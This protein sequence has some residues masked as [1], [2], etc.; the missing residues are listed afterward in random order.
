MSCQ[1]DYNIATKYKAVR[2]HLDSLGYDLGFSL[3]CLPLIEKLLADLIQTTESLKHFK[4]IAQENIE[5]CCKLQSTIDPYKCDNIRLVRECNDLHEHLIA[6]K[7]THD[8]QVRDLKKQIKKLENE[9]SGFQ[10]ASSRNLKKIKELEIETSKKSK[11]ILELQGK[12]SKPHLTNPGLAN[13]KRNCHPLRRPALECE[14]LPKPSNS[15]PSLPS[16]KA[17]E[18]K[19]FDLLNMADHKMNCLSYEAATKEKEIQRLRKLLE[20]GRPH[21]A[22]VSDCYCKNME[23]HFNESQDNR[24]V[25]EL[26]ILQQTKLELEKELKDALQKQHEAMSHAM[27]LAE[28]NEELEKELRDIDNIAL[29][30]EA[31]CNTAVKVNHMRVCK[32]QQK[33]DD[34]VTQVHV[35]E[36]ELMVERREVQELRADLTACKLEKRNIQ[37]LFESALD[38]KKQM[39]DKINQLMINAS[40]NRRHSHSPPVL[41]RSN[42]HGR[43][44]MN[45]EN[46]VTKDTNNI[47][48]N[49]M[50]K[51]INEKDAQV[52]SLQKTI[53]KL[54][55]ERDFYKDEYN[56]LKDQYNKINGSDNM[57]ALARTNELHR[58]LAEKDHVLAELQ[59]EKHELCREKYNLESRLQ[60]YCKDY[61]RNSCSPCRQSHTCN[62]QVL[63]SCLQDNNSA[64]LLIDRLERERDTAKADVDRLVQERDA[65]RE[66][67]QVASETHKCEQKCLRENLVDVQNRLKNIE[68]ERHDVSL[69]QVTQRATISGLEDQLDDLRRELRRTKEE[70]ASQRTQ[71][72]QLKALQDQTDQALGDVQCQLTQSE[73]ELTKAVDRNRCMEQQQMQMDQQVKGLKQEINTLRS[74]MAQLDHEKDQLLMLLDEKTEKIEALE[75]DIMVKEQQTVGTEQQIRELQHKNEICVDQSAEQERQIRNLQMEIENVQRQLETSSSDRENAIQEN[76]RLQDDLASVSCEVRTLHREL[77]TSRA[78][79]SDLKRQLQTYVSEVRRAEELLNRKENERTEMLNHF[80]SLSLEASVLENNNHSLESEAAEARGALESARDKLLDLERQLADKESLTREYETQITQLTQSVASLEAQLRQQTEQREMAEAD[81]I[82]VRDLCMKLD[83]QK[84]SLMLQL[85]DKD[86]MKSQYEN[87][88]ARLKTEQNV[89]QDQLSRDR[90]A[91]DRLESLLDEARQESIKAQATNQQLQNEILRLKHKISDLQGK[92]CSESAE[93]RQYQNQAAEYNKQIIELRRQVTNER[94][95]RAMKDEESRRSSQDRTRKKGKDFE[96]YYSDGENDLIQ[97]RQAERPSLMQTCQERPSASQDTM[98]V[99]KMSPVN[100]TSETSTRSLNSTPDSFN[101]DLN[102]VI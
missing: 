47:L 38:E 30:V 39:T 43:K 87:Q 9:C 46:E 69:A 18:P 63:S 45:R 44:S 52:A 29:A 1:E 11:K 5:T 13:K 58:Q 3:D 48:Q 42:D 80:R 50:Q 28:R 7:E 99:R 60:S 57:E 81:L 2:K 86:T 24:E 34:V 93:L 51:M 25:S 33:L 15:S 83:H 14:P 74:N 102:V 75:R 22:V 23:E 8:Q 84:D 59:K 79:A 88:L 49:H 10:L 41:D 56:K 96:Y 27:K 92:L 72:F 66:K 67:Y 17:V 91:K 94:F 16:L 90:A 76:R 89:Q 31:D 98:R 53:G 12:C 4:A 36:N 54:E 68:R 73:S 77:E 65:L 97:L 40:K 64:K 70:L 100:R 21:T 19:T 32:L 61:H 101:V 95:D 82:A 35:L 20:G 55:T 71:Y 62:Y 26:R 85:E 6:I 37:C 78:E